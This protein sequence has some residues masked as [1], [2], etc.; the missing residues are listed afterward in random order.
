MATA[1]VIAVT[2]PS[3]VSGGEDSV[4]PGEPSGAVT[5]VPLEYQET[6]FEFLFRDVPAERRLVP[7]PKEP[8][9]VHGPVVRGMLK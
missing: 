6:R 2:W 3:A 7:F 5:T 9:P 4:R 1:A 8:A